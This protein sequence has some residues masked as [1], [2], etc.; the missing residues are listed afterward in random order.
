MRT[1]FQGEIMKIGSVFQLSGLGKIIASGKKD[2]SLDNS[3]TADGDSSLLNHPVTQE[4]TD[5][6]VKPSRAIGGLSYT[7]FEQ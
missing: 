3:F 7:I 1:I 5:A 2:A 6:Y 4:S